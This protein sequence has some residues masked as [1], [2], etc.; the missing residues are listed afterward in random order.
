MFGRIVYRI[1]CGFFLGISV[2]APGFSG[3][4]IAITMGIYEDILRIVANPFKQ[5]KQNIVFCIPL[6]IGAGFSAVL[7]VFSFSY[8]FNSNSTAIYLLFVGLIAGNLPIILSFIKKSG[9][10]K[11][12]LAGG[13]CSFAIAVAFA[14]S[15]V[16]IV[17]LPG[18]DNSSVNIALLI[19]SGFAGG[20]TALIPGMSVSMVLIIMGVYT[21][22]INMADSLFRL[23]FAYLVPFSLFALAAVIGL[24]LTSRGIKYVFDRYPGFANT[25]VFGFVSGSLVGILLQVFR[26]TDS[27][28]IRLSDF[29]MLIVGFGVSM[30]FVVMRN[31][32][33][34]E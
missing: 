7:F 24:V 21:Q 33:Q 22:L 1:I 6:A 13:L 26:I 16:G 19:L 9:F 28:S 15:A 27:G 29:I 23:N 34:G 3:S 32:L 25:L 31:K 10:K 11:H 17:L 30:L 20:A 5:L 12:Y 8:L 2:F 4:V 14:I 18:R